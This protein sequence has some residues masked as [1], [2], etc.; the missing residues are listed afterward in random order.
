MDG[1]SWQAYCRKLLRIRYQDY[2]D[3]PAQFG[4]DLGIDGLTLSGLVFQ[5]YC[6]EEDPTGIELY[7]YQRDKI[8]K[9]IAKLIKNAGKI[10]ALGVGIIQEW[11]FLTPRYNNRDLLSHCRSKEREVIAC[12]IPT[13]HADFKI[14]L[15]TEEDYIPERQVL[16]GMAGILI[17]PASDEPPSAELKKLLRSDNEIV[18]NI[19]TKLK[20]LSLA[21]GQRSYLTRQLVGGYVAGQNEL[22]TLNDKFPSVYHSLI[23]LKSATESQLAIRALS[24]DGADGTILKDVLDTYQSKLA[25]D[26]SRNLS[27]A[28]IT[29]LATEAISDWLGRC[30]LDFPE[31]EDFNEHH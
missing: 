16:L 1:N 28:L 14:L 25:T 26:F 15:K 18:L 21:S 11:H 19:Q 2:Q 31:P 10:S 20:R 23:Q 17:Q 6:P 24:C 27:S 7:N 4:G 9:D 29:R 12:N 30:P 8:T 5:C 13:I 22:Q 3:V